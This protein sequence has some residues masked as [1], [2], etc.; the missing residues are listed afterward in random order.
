MLLKKKV[1]DFA[2]WINK[3]LVFM[4]KEEESLCLAIRGWLLECCL[5]GPG[6]VYADDWAR[7]NVFFL[8]DKTLVYQM[9]VFHTSAL[10]Y[11]DK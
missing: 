10:F 8:L 2:T 4:L 9:F 1:S 3:I 5:Q 7:Y 11:I 6:G